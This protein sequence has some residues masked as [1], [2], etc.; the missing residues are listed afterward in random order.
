MLSWA[1]PQTSLIKLFPSFHSSS[2]FFEF[3][4][5]FSPWCVVGWGVMLPGGSWRQPIGVHPLV[6]LCLDTVHCFHAWTSAQ[7]HHCCFSSQLASECSIM[8]KNPYFFI[9][10]SILQ[11]PRSL[12][13]WGWKDLVIPPGCCVVSSCSCRA[14]LWESCTCAILLRCTATWREF[15]RTGSKILVRRGSWLLKPPATTSLS[16]GRTVSCLLYL[17]EK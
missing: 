16:F 4:S 7:S 1:W 12:L 10:S 6:L 9:N 17:L 15:K 13:E 8:N 3:Q 5:G 11:Y 2:P 14:L